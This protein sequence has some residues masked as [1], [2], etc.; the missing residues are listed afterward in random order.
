MK[1]P[2]EKL[3]IRRKKSARSTLAFSQKKER[4]R[5]PKER[6]EV[7][8]LVVSYSLFPSPSLF[9]CVFFLVGAARVPSP[10]LPPA[11]APAALLRFARARPQ[12]Q[13]PQRLHRSGDLRPKQTNE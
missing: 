2:K 1:E 13:P 3:W 10:P 5:A 6:G 4:S 11:R 8:A 7:S 12:L 9:S